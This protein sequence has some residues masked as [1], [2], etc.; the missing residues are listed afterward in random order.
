MGIAGYIALVPGGP[1]GSPTWALLRPEGGMV[2]TFAESSTR[3]DVRRA[4]AKDGM[5]LR[6]DNK[7]ERA[8]GPGPETRDRPGAVTG[9]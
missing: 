4:L 7:V 5:R 6:D 3:E 2:S 8:P 1:F 9:P